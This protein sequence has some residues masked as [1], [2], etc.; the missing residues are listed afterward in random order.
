MGG[1]NDVVMSLDVND[2][3]FV[4]TNFDTDN[5][6]GAYNVMLSKIYY[7]YLMQDTGY[8]DGDIDYSGVD[9]VTTA[10][11]I[12]ILI[13]TPPKMFYNYAWTTGTEEFAGYVKRIADLWGIP[14]VDANSEMEINDI[15]KDLYWTHQTTPDYVHF[16]PLGH[17]NLAMLIID[18]LNRIEPLF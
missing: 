2:S 7:K 13:I 15:N 17:E 10:K 5:F 3:D 18:K 11:N 12:K 1:T 14:C 4:I 6:V 9:Q 16:S 8:Y